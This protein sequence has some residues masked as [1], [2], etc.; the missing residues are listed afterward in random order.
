[1]PL[2]VVDPRPALPTLIVVDLQ[3]GVV[4]QP[5]PGMAEVVSASASLA[6]AFRSRGF[7]VVLVN[8]S[9]GVPGRTDRNPAGGS[10]ALPPEAQ[11]LDPSLGAADLVVTKRTH[12][13]FHGTPLEA[14]LAERG[15]TQIFVTGVATGSGVE[16]TVREGLARGLNVVTVADAMLDREPAVHDFCVSTVFPKLS[17]VATTAEV[18]AAI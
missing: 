17:Q 12:G 13:A 16:A 1:M 11:V 18:L 5:L 2:T 14:W 3:S 15:V 6:A 4:S 10:R 7:P 8:V 9:H